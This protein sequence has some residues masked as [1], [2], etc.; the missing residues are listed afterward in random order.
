[1][2]KLSA[3]AQK[4][5]NEELLDAMYFGN[6]AG[7]RVALEAGADVKLQHRGKPLMLVA[8]EDVAF[9]KRP[10]II[11]LLSEKGIDV[12]V[13]GTTALHHAVWQEDEGSVNA[14]LTCGVDVNVVND[15]GE[16]ALHLAA[17]KGNREFLQL[18]CEQ[19]GINLNACDKDKKT[20]IECAADNKHFEAFDFLKSKGA[21]VDTEIAARVERYKQE[22]EG[23]SQQQLWTAI[24][25]AD[26][27]GVKQAILKG[28]NVNAVGAYDAPVATVVENIQC[29]NDQTRRAAWLD[30]ITTLVRYGAD[31]NA[32]NSGGRTAVTRAGKNQEILDRLDPLRLRCWPVVKYGIGFAAIMGIL[33]ASISTPLTAAIVT[34]A[35]FLVSSV[36]L[37]GRNQVIVKEYQAE[38]QARLAQGAV[39]LS[40]PGSTLTPGKDAGLGGDMP[41]PARPASPSSSPSP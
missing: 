20:A 28:A 30:I 36:I 8:L 27:E 41:P 16:T 15:K 32:A 40:E 29:S 31:I 19:P 26:R 23:N 7:V 17:R 10:Q 9:E 22:K 35:T 12:Q 24:K 33:A 18:L 3:E 5:V 11:Q 21:I 6:I 39:N 34:V 2:G 14:L 25:N 4:Q 38:V 37:W 13:R 1:M